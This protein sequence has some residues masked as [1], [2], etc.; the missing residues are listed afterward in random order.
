MSS[1]YSPI[2]SGGMTRGDVKNLVRE[3]GQ[4]DLFRQVSECLL[5]LVAEQSRPRALASGEILLS[6]EQDNDSIHV[7]LS[8]KLS[9]HFESPSAPAIRELAAGVS[10]GELSLIDESR[11]SAYVVAQEPCRVLPIHRALLFSLIA[12]DGVVACNMLRILTRW[13]KC[14]TTQIVEHRRTIRELTGA[15]ATLPASC[16]QQ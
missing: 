3:L 10:V 9:I 14:N 1:T 5:Y 13:I 4:S 12:E 11:P 6:P 2:H 8:G 16:T 7:L 15:A